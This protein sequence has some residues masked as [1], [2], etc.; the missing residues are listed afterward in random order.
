MRYQIW[1]KTDDIFT[2]AGTKFAAEE[3][4]AR[5]PWVKVPGAKMV[6]TTGLINGGAAME[7]G[8]TVAHY[9]AQGAAITDG[10]SD[11]EI[12]AAIEDFEDNPPGADEP[13]SEERIA[14]ALEAQVLMAEPDAVSLA[15]TDGA[16]TMSL[17][18]AR[19]RVAD[20]VPSAAFER[21]KRNYDR[22]LW[23]A[24]LVSLAASKG[25]I[26]EVEAA[27]ILGG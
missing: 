15:E 4:A 13:S 17:R 25:Q 23:G 6:I 19:A 9:K 18:K 26:S 10:M 21:V 2:P 12:L 24:A 8:A 7:F 22:G 11:E 16:S 3:W 1:N 27:S 20:P 5:Y 14:A